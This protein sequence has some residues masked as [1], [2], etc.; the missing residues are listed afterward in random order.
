MVD[1][2]GSIAYGGTNPDETL[3]PNALKGSGAAHVNLIRKISPEFLIGAEYMIG[4]R[5]N[6]NDADGTAQRIQFSSMYSF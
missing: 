4:R 6:A 3:F 2:L 5:E 1:Q